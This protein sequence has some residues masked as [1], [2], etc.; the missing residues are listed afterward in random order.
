MR[1]GD[2]ARRELLTRAAQLFDTNGYEAVSIKDI[3]E[4]LGWPKSLFYYYCPSKE[5]LVRQA[6]QL[7]AA[8]LMDDLRAR[9]AE[10]GPD[11]AERLSRALGCAAFWYGDAA[12]AADRLRTLYGEGNLPWRAYLRRHICDGLSAVCAD[13]IREGAAAYSLYTPYPDA[14]AH[15]AIDLT[16]DLSERLAPL[17]MAG[18]AVSLEQAGALLDAYRCA[19]ERLVEAPFGALRLV[20][21]GMLRDIAQRYAQPAVGQI[22][23]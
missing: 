1:K 8:E 9:I 15:A 20:E 4:S 19:V 22:A 18:D 16:A 14:M 12:A 21:L 7:R 10:G 13:V 17:V 23:E 5:L 3:A 11:C 2:E 6:A